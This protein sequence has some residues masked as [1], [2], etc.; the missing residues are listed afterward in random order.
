MSHNLRIYRSSAGSGKTYTLALSFIGLALKG[1][2]YGYEDYYRKILAIT[3]TNKAASEMK[4]RVL[5][6]LSVLSSKEDV[7]EIL[8]WLMKETGLD[9]NTIFNR[10][11]VVYKHIL[12][13]YA[14]LG[15]LTIDKFTYKI[16]RTFA[17]DLGLSSNFDVEM[18]NYKIIQP[19]VALLLSKV[20]DNGSSFS[21]ALVNF[22]T[23]KAVDGKSSNIERDLEDFAQKLFKEELIYYKDK[24]LTI[25]SSLEV[26]KHLEKSKKSVTLSIKDLAGKVYLFFD[27]NGLTKNHFRG[28]IFFNHFTRN[29]FSDDD[30]RWKP[31]DT[32]LRNIADDS[33]YAKSSRKEAK[34]LVEL[35]KPYLIEFVDE[36]MIL[37]EE[38][39][40]VT[41]VL[42]NIDVIAVL[43]EL[44][45]EIKGFKRE[46]NIEQIA[47][48]NKKINAVVS[49][50]PSS[51]IYE[52]IGERYQHYLIDEFQD[53]SLLQWQNI[54]PLI[55]D[56]LDF[57]ASMLVGDGKQSIYRWRGGEVEQFLK[58]PHIFKGDNLSFKS[59]W[60]RKLC[61]HY[62]SDNL[63]QNYRSRKNIIE[64]NNQFFENVR[65]VLPNSLASIYDNLTQ[66]TSQAKEGGYVHIELFGDRKNDFKGLIL[67]KMISEI[68]KLT[69][70]NNYSYKNITILCNSRKSVA[71]VAENLSA[72]GI[73]VISNEG[74]LLSRSDKV[75]VLISMLQHLQNKQD[76]VPKV[77]IAE[78][79]YRYNLSHEVLHEVH[80]EIKSSEGFLA[81]LKR[82]GIYIN[83]AQLLQESLYEIVEQLISSFNFKQDIYI[84]FF[85]DLVLD[86]TEQKGNGI[87]DF[88]CWWKER[89]DKDT[90]AIPEGTDAVQIMTIHKSKGLAFDVV[91]IPFNWEDRKR[92]F[93][94]WVD[95]S[96]YFNRQLPTALIAGSSKLETSYFKDE[97]Q[98]EQ[99]MILLDSLN[100]IYVAMTRPKERLYVFSKYFPK[101]LQGYEKKGNLNSFF[102]KFNR[103]TPIIIGDAEMMCQ[104]KEKDRSPFQ[105][106]ERSK[107]NWRDIISLKH[108][109]EAIWNTKEIDVKRDWGRLIHLVLSEINYFYEK[110]I[111]IKKMYQLGKF[112]KEDYQEVQSVISRLLEHKQIRPFFTDNWEVKNEKEILMSNGKTC[113]PD[114][115]LFSKE[116]DKVVVIDYKTGAELEENKTQIT[117]YANAL[118]LMGKTNIDRILIYISGVI[119]V[120]RL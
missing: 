119:K 35:L 104:S 93:D 70:V 17:S 63:Q 118:K 57:G 76:D 5:N 64:F 71:L 92:N 3:F 54:L 106:Q 27:S 115:L 2:R 85:L 49:Q 56:S 81:V 20:S 102:Y 19:A 9:K 103:E 13:N 117:E 43:N 52:R 67:Q 77:I 109:A 99:E 26:K 100:K 95:T 39:Y 91:M 47:E 116:S 66:E 15:I 53:T 75:K 61:N 46:N 24:F 82:A 84:D 1:G 74:L 90:I 18:D 16:I 29:L 96:Q 42:N 28:G 8:C 41:S 110:D 21:N 68:C 34:D 11:N 78:Y 94:I 98:R 7:D 31:T 60:E 23:K 45:Q 51:F 4:E 86:Y 97:Y 107:L 89:A 69:T 101:S 113:I 44:M 73:P 33:W 65:G 30:S 12:H 79:V 32:L 59:V 14:D 111:V 48:F 10:S 40:S 114:R 58:L 6:Y 87:S 120:V 112:T 105:C 55:T 83:T 37:L 25:Q 88:L 80:L 108:S 62:I 50:Q 36:L 72:N 22:A 38:Y